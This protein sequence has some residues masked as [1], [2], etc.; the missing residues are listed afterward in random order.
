MLRHPLDR[1]KGGYR[2]LF[3]VFLLDISRT[4]VAL[5]EPPLGLL[6]QNAGE[7]LPIQVDPLVARPVEAVGKILQALPVNVVD[8]FVNG[9]LGVLELQWRQCFL[10]VT[11]LWH[12]PVTGLSRR[13]DKRS[14]RVASSEIVRVI[15]DVAV[16]EICGTHQAVPAHLFLIGEVVEHQGSLTQAVGPHLEAGSVGGER[17][18]AVEPFS[19]VAWRRPVR[20][21]LSVVKD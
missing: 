7:P 2:S 10:E 1:C 5:V 13:G 11:A 9:C 8:F 17:V 3:T 15:A 4:Q 6:G 14:D 16:N 19:T 18:V 21:V 12:A 20:I